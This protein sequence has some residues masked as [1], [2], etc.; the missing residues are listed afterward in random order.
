MEAL[1]ILRK[2]L[3]FACDRLI[4]SAENKLA[5]RLFEKVNNILKT[6]ENFV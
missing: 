1:S 3:N 5:L 4:N 2:W 6:T